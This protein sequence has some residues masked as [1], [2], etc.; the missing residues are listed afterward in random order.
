MDFAI[1]TDARHWFRS[2]RGTNPWEFTIDFD[3]FYF[4]FIAGVACL[5]KRPDITHAETSPLVD[6]FPGRYRER[7]HLLVALLLRRELDL[8]GILLEEKSAVRKQIARLIRPD[9]RNHLTDEGVREFNR[10]A[11]GGFD[12]LQDWFGGDPQR[13]AS[14]GHI[15]D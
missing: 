14:T 15:S 10:F 8:R 12:V 1:R 3:G 2:V 4:C 5:R 13:A 9:A 11:H 7:G 6:Y